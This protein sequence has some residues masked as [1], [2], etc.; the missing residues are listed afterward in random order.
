MARLSRSLPALLGGGLFLVLLAVASGHLYSIDGLQY[1]R[2]AERIVYDHSLTFDPPLVWGTPIRVPITPIGFSLVQIPAVLLAA[3]LRALQPALGG[4]PYDMPLLYGDPLYTAA[5]WVNPAIVALTGALV[6]SLGI[7]LGMGQRRATL[8]ALASTLG[9]PLFFY[10]RADFAQPLAGLLLLA[11]ASVLVDLF[12]GRPAPFG[13]LAGLVALSILTRPVDGL[14]VAILAVI[15]MALPSVGWK[16]W[17]D[18]RRPA[19]DLGLGIG[20]GVGITLVVDQLRRG[21]ALDVGYQANFFGS[22]PLGLV[23][24]LFSPGRGLLWY[25]PLLALVP[26][27]AVRLWRG[28]RWR[29]LLILGLPVAAYLPI[30][31]MWQGLGGWAWGPRFMIP[32]V[33]LLALLAGEAIPAFRSR[34]GA[35][36]LVGGLGLAGGLDN[37][38]SLAVDQLRFWGTYGDSVFGT[39]GFW[40]QFE[41]GSFAPL[42]SWQ[43]Y[44]PVSGPDIFWLREASTTHGLSM[45]I[46]LL[47]LG[48]GMALLAIAWRRVARVL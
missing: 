35:T 21:A 25:F 6:L 48:A 43:F 38:A 33:P 37:L 11:V 16:P 9:S 32:L 24:E 39:P 8:V 34:L 42:G 46:G 22:L 13:V 5:S 44:D 26:V 10:A 19:I 23:A 31:A 47:A 1:F 20:A 29:Q 2:V 27:G 15:V 7:R 30:Y 18:A 41:L 4:G 36:L 3:P 40:R 17:L 14:I 28:G 12:D 45:L